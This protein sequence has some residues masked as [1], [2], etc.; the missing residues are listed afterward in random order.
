MAVFQ[1][2]RGKLALV[3]HD[4]DDLANTAL[5]SSTFIRQSSFFPLDTESLHHITL[6]TQDE[7][8]NLTPEQVSKLTTL[9]PDTSHLFSTGIGGKLQSNAHECWVVIIWAAGQQIRKQF[10]LPPKHFY[11]PLYGDDVHD[12]D[13]GVSSLFPGQNVTTSSAEVLDHVVFTLQ[14]FGLY[15]EAQAYSIRFIHLDPLSYKGFLRL[16]DAALGGKRY[17]MAMLSYA[18]AFER[19]SEDRIR[20]YCVK[21]LVECSKETEW[22]LVFQEHEADEIEALKEIS[23]LLLSPWSQALRETVSEQELTPSLML[24]TRQSLFVPS[25]STFMGKNF[26]KLPRFFRWLIPY[27]LAIMST[28]RNE[29]DIIA[30]ASAALGIRHVLTLTEETPLHESWFRGKTITNTFLPIPNFHPPSIEQMDLIIGLFKDEKKLPM[31]VHCGGGK[32]RAGTVAA[33]YIAA[34]GFNKPR[35]NQDH[36]EFTAAEAI[37]SL[38]ALRPGSLETKQQE[39]FVSKWCSTIW[40]RQSVYPDLPSEPLPTPLEVE[41]VLNDEGDLFVL[42]GLPGSG[43][44]WFS[45]SLLARQSSGW[46]HIS[47]DDSRSRDSCETEIGRTP[48]KGKRVILDRCNTSASD[49]KSWLA[50]ASNWCVSPI[51]IWFDYDQELCISRAQMRAGHPTLPPGSRVRNAV[52]QMQRVFVKPSLEEGFKAII[53]VRSFSAAQEAILRLSSPIAILKFPRTPHLINLGAASSDDVHTDVS[54]F[55]NVA[56]AARGCV[57]ITEKIDGANMGF[58]LSSTGDILVQNRSH[59]VNSAT[60]E[61]FK[62]LRLWLDRHEE[63][64][65]SILARDP[66]FL[67]RYIL[68]GEWT[69]ATHSIPYTH[70][71]DYFIAYDLFDRSTGAWADTK[72]LHNLLEATTI[73]SVPLIRQG[74]MPTDTELLQMIQQPSAFYE[75]RVEGVYVK[76]EVNGHVKLRGKVVRSDF[77]AGNEHWTRGRIRVNGLKSNP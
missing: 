23:S 20:A 21:K 54:S 8:R 66:Y 65:R 35:E 11:I 30:L 32:G 33:C 29:D 22:G 47:Q 25:P 4:I 10:G 5:G 62:K 58:S 48:Q 43:K 76:V 46:V 63:D 39:A 31:L 36:P 77:I 16:G 50:L 61:Q 27:H 44:S 38:R 37:S 75:G 70:L 6:F 13:R 53:T 72:T 26:Y 51:C 40:K 60:H 69:Y 14:A 57:V 56:T 17:K 15:D 64:L 24:E 68:Y 59:Y 9:E 49:R 7:I 28:P 41:G 42:V 3:G 1:K 18:N 12:I 55:A 67:E 45:D 2:Y 34:F 71:P 52:E 73:A 19:I 74:D